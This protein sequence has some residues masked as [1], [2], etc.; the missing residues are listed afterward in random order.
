MRDVCTAVAATIGEGG[1]VLEFNKKAGVG[2][3]VL[4]REEE[5]GICGLVSGDEKNPIE[6]EADA[7]ERLGEMISWIA[8]GAAMGVAGAEA[9]CLGAWGCIGRRLGVDPCLFC[10]MSLSLDVLLP[11][12]TSSG[13]SGRRAPNR[14][15][16]NLT[17]TRFK[18]ERE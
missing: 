14:E 10:L 1:G 17:K 11:V 8:E 6:G 12:L 16:A 9:G 3:R 15:G 4:E 18:S 2:E 5:G 13:M 7:E